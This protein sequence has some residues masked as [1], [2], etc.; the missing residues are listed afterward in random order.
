[1]RRSAPF[2]VIAAAV[3]A[4]AGC[5]NSAYPTPTVD[6][7]TAAAPTTPSAPTSERGFLVKQIGETGGWGVS[8]GDISVKFVV[9]KITVDPQCTNRFAS[10]SEHGHFVQVDMRVETTPTMPT[11]MG[12]QINPFSW[13]AVGAD[14]VTESSI[15]TGSSYSCIDNSKQLTTQMTPGSKYR[16]SLVFDV[17]SPTGTLLFPHPNPSLGGWEWTYGAA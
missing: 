8:N 13:S 9:D 17:T 16:G 14:G 4:L 2:V 11:N 12:Y 10:A 3:F 6:V 7:P 5:S 1:M 15:A